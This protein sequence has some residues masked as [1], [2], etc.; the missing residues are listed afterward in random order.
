MKNRMPTIKAPLAA[1][2]MSALLPLSIVYSLPAH[3][4]GGADV[5]GGNGGPA[6]IVRITAAGLD[7]LADH[8]EIVI[9]GRK[10]DIQA[11]QEALATLKE[12]R[13]TD[14]KL[15]AVNGKPVCLINH[16]G[17][18]ALDM[19]VP[20]FE[21]YDE[22]TKL[23][24]GFH[25][26]WGLAFADHQDDTYYYS[27]KLV[28]RARQ[29]VP[30]SEHAATEVVR[31]PGY[32]FGTFSKE[33]YEANPKLHEAIVLANA[34]KAAAK[35]CELADGVI[36]SQ[37]TAAISVK[38]S[39]SP[40]GYWAQADGSVRCEIPK[41]KKLPLLGVDATVTNDFRSA[42]NL[43]KNGRIALLKAA[44]EGVKNAASKECLLTAIKTN[45]EISL[46]ADLQRL[47]AQIE[48]MIG[49][50]SLVYGLS[51][52]LGNKVDEKGYDIAPKVKPP[53]QGMLSVYT[54]NPELIQNRKG[55]IVD[56]NK[57]YFSVR[58]E[59]YDLNR[60][61]IS[62]TDIACGTDKETVTK[63]LKTLKAHLSS[64]DEGDD[65]LPNEEPISGSVQ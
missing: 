19:N 37:P 48:E 39:S 63:F 21:A 49:P 8:G 33:E 62:F 22:D 59:V 38:E 15:P 43:T 9:N 29:R 18:K 45:R 7:A 65:L 54:S 10:I 64:L 35:N 12:I 4:A 30:A 13:P 56:F 27:A 2:L 23:Q 42:T 52:G 60:R 51:L 14:E 25:E 50:F 24:M 47:K 6:K 61:T 46:D 34:E 40:G 57:L 3:A 36:R 31:T 11:M 58:G 32:S 5:G 44:E 28:Q 41:P 20:C 16:P 1:L 55:R 17:A 26:V 53:Y